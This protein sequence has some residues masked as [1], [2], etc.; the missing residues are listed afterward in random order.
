MPKRIKIIGGPGCGK[1]SE[2]IDAIGQD[3][4]RMFP[5]EIAG[6]SLTRTAA[7]NMKRRVVKTLRVSYDDIPNMGT[8]H[9]LCWRL[10]DRPTPADHR[11]AKFERYDKRT[12]DMLQLLRQ[13]MIPPAEWPVKLRRYYT[14]YCEWMS[15]NDLMDFTGML[16]FVLENRLSIDEIRSMYCDEAQD[17]TPLIWAV[18]TMWAETAEAFYMGG[19][20]DQAIFDFMG[21]RPGLFIGMPY[22][23]LRQRKQSYRL[24]PSIHRYAMEIIRGC[25]CRDDYEYNPVTPELVRRQQ[26]W[27]PNRLD[28]SEG[29]ILPLSDEP[30]LSLPGT[31]MIIAM[32]NTP[33]SPFLKRWMDWL[34]KHNIPFHNP[35]RKRDLTLNPPLTKSW[36]AAK[37]YYD[38]V[39]G[40]ECDLKDL[41]VMADM[42]IAKETFARGAKKRFTGLRP[43]KTFNLESFG[44]LE[45]GFK[46]EFLFPD[47]P[48]LERFVKLEGEAKKMIV[49]LTPDQL[50]EEPRVILSTPQG[51]KGGEADTVWECLGIPSHVRA[52]IYRNKDRARDKFRRVRYVTVS[53]ARM[54]YGPLD[55]SMKISKD[56]CP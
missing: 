51:V 11:L 50:R 54:N 33:R 29:K 45:H 17:M 14:G 37:T 52:E 22:D 3:C 7:R 10:C 12:H 43:R 15:D 20:G 27:Y 18:V 8:A 21:A 34:Y 25:E 36:Q 9:S 46:E 13:Q 35:Y 39:G 41:Q 56:I 16:E 23:E 19:D 31:H 1:T 47:K 38:M 48:D 28:W 2:I 44:L 49:K 5:H 24:S 40:L 55:H 4:G 30:D 42:C 6:V 32:S 53:R 26:E